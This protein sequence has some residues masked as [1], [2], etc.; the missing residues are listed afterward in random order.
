MPWPQP[1]LH[2]VSLIHIL[3]FGGVSA[4]MVAA[5]ALQAAPARLPVLAMLLVMVYVAIAVAA[6]SAVANVEGANPRSKW[7][8]RLAQSGTAVVMVMLPPLRL[9]AVRMLCGAIPRERALRKSETQL[10]HL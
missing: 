10:E 1:S 2:L 6:G 7:L 5:M 8:R 9:I 4:G 3:C